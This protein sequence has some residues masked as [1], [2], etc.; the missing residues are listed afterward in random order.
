M[1]V[2]GKLQKYLFGTNKEREME[3]MRNKKEILYVF[4]LIV[5]VIGSFTVGKYSEKQ[6][7]ANETK[8]QDIIDLNDIQGWDTYENDEEV[9]LALYIGDDTYELTK[10]PFSIPKDGCNVNKTE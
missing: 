1:I 8:S 9:G 2:I 10:E 4:V 6:R 7:I 5:L 3:I